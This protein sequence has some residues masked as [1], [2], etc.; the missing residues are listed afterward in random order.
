ML[1]LT[2][3]AQKPI[4]FPDIT[5]NSRFF[6][7]VS[8][9]KAKGFINGYSDGAFHP[10]RDVNRAEALA[11][12]LKVSRG[13]EISSDLE[14]E[15][16]PGAPMQ[17][18]F[19]EAALVTIENLSTGEKTD[20]KNIKNLVIEVE[21]GSAKLKLRKP[22]NKKPFLDV[23]EKDWFYDIAKEG[24]RLGIVTGKYL[25][26]NNP[27]NLAEAL[28][29]L[30]KSASIKPHLSEGT[31]PEGV[32]ADLWYAPDIAYAVKNTILTQKQNGAIFPPYET[33]N[34]GEMALLLYR[35]LKMK[36]G[37][38]FGYASWYGDGLAKTKLTEN[39]EYAE[40]NLTAAHRSLPFGT[41]VR[42]TNIMNGK[43]VDVVVNDRGPFVTG[44]IIDLSKTAFS[45]LES[46]SAGII[47]VEIYAPSPPL[48]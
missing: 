32:A 23:S 34:R 25:R 12:I 13:A 43:T 7:P 17:I 2:T 41:I 29:M 42:V 28:R 16:M 6:I 19:P 30:F 24:K 1:P 37:A 26:P 48:P 4:P 21:A 10:Q 20:V 27:V 9:L 44:R 18:S 39:K 15:I 45:A 36:Q 14:K 3:S 11:M 47:S 35:F 5:E 33:L 40:K 22:R 31:L 38:S 8:F 46:P